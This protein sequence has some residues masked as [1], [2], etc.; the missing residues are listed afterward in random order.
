MTQLCKILS[1]DQE[2]WGVHSL[3]N[4]LKTQ[5]RYFEA[6]ASE[7][8]ASEKPQPKLE[9]VQ[10]AASQSEYYISYAWKDSSPE[11]T[12]REATVDQLCNV[13]EKDHSIKIIRDKENIGL[14]ES[15]L[16]FMKRIGKADK[17]F[18]ILSD[19]YLK[20]PYCM[21]E[22]FEIWRNSRQE[23]DEFLQHIR[24]YILPCTNIYTPLGRGQYAVF[25]KNEKKN[26]EEL[27]EKNGADILGVDDFR[28]F[29]LMQD[30][31]HHVGDI[32]ALIVDKVQPRKFEELIQYGFDGSVN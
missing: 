27:I 14:G 9:F 24:T 11:G 15:I 5:H 25:W 26:L 12:E 30:F 3:S 21:F 6:G 29:K 16:K 23:E 18:V 10:E 2:R 13:A 8:E 4:P 17:V 7:M 22:L 32:L 1:D 20:S 28:Q 19:K 31:T